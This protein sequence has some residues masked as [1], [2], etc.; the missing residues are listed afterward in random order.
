[1]NR[2]YKHK[3]LALV[4]E[5]N[6]LTKLGQIG[7]M[8]FPNEFGGFLVGNYSADFKTLHIL[9][10][11]LPKKYKGFPMYFERAIDGLTQIFDKL[12]KKKNQYFIGEW[13][14]HPNGSTMYSQTDLNSMIQT[15]ECETVHIN[16]PILLIISLNKTRVLNHTFYIYQNKNLIPYE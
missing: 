9:D 13:H 14:T 2:T 16:N 15:A 10:Y 12:F 6:L 5:D 1:L 7:I 3:N 11:V 4:I 8:H